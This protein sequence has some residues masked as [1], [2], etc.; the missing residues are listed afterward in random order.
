M[1]VV[2]KAMA[3]RQASPPEVIYLLK[4]TSGNA[5]INISEAEFF[6][7]MGKLQDGC[8]KENSR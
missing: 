8:V 5:Y 6:M 7:R 3:I 2:M 4:C 1:I